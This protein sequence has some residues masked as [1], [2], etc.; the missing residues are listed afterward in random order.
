LR[1]TLRAALRGGEGERTSWGRQCGVGPVSNWRVGPAAFRQD[2]FHEG[3]F[4][5]GPHWVVP[6]EAL[7][8]PHY[9][10]ERIR[11]ESA[12]ACHVGEDTGDIPPL[13][14]RAPSGLGLQDPEGDEVFG[15]T[16]G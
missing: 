6:G 8:P 4:L 14:L 16:V 12:A 2:R 11:Q 1:A 9:D 5:D 15:W 10:E 7:D 3:L 13:P